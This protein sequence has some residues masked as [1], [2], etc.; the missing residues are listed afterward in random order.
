VACASLHPGTNSAAPTRSDGLTVA[1]RLDAADA[2]GAA[3]R[4]LRSNGFDIDGAATSGWDVRTRAR[5]IGADTSMIVSALVTPVDLAPTKAM[6]TLS[7]TISVAHTRIHN[8][9]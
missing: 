6:V 7:A 4:A 9:Q 8:R 5:R 1:S 2:R 3:I